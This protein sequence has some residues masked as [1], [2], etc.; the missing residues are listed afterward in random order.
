[1]ATYTEQLQR[2]AN[3]YMRETGTTEATSR[4]IAMW[5]ITNH[6]WEPQ[7]AALVKQCA[8]EIS[9]AMREEYTTDEQGRRVRSKHVAMMER[10]GEQVR[11][12]ADLRTATR[13]H[14]EIAFQQRRQQIV[15]DC[16]QLKSD[17]D[18]YNENY[19]SAEAIQ[20]I[21]DFTVD[22]EEA[23]YGDSGV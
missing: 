3:E 1:M 14:M 17:V 5:A 10:S 6:F 2:I 11:L 8:E 23:V 21:F 18:S 9:R 19:N 22:L 7:P 15:G 12:W 13:E 20:I 16:R 4:E